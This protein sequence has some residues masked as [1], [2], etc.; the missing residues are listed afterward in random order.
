MAGITMIG[1][2]VGWMSYSPH[3]IAPPRILTYFVVP[4]SFYLVKLLTKKNMN[5]TVIVVC[6]VMVLSALSSMNQ[7]IYLDTSITEG[8]YLAVEELSELG[9][10]TNLPDWWTDYTI[11][12]ALFYKINRTIKWTLDTN[13]T[14]IENVKTDRTDFYNEALNSNETIKQFS[15]KYVFISER[16]KT[17]AFFLT[18]N[19][20]DSLRGSHIRINIIDLWKNNPNWVLIYEKHGVLVYEKR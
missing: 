14:I 15:Y 20:P 19:T 18:Q 1:F 9:L 12:S 2:I 10:I 13:F 6:A 7:M 4:F 8:E 17:Q 16:M 3:L 5:Q 11:N